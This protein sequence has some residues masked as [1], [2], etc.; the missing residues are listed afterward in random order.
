MRTST[1]PRQASGFR[2]SCSSGRSRITL[3]TFKA[4]RL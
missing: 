1:G 3:R 4:S 2:S